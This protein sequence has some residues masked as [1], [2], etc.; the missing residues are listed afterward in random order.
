MRMLPQLQE[1]LHVW[2]IP[3][4]PRAPMPAWPLMQFLHSMRP[5]PRTHPQANGPALSATFSNFIAFMDLDAEGNVW[6]R[7]VH[8]CAC[9]EPLCNSE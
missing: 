9:Q 4:M 6:I 1:R 8:A 2:A 5:A 7:C 3:S